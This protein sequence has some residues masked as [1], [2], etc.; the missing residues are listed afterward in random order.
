MQ[1]AP[2][3]LEDVIATGLLDERIPRVRKPAAQARA[4]SELKRVL[5]G[6]PRAVLQKLVEVALE[7][8]QAQSAGISLLE[9]SGG[10][11]F[12]RWHAVAGEWSGLLWSTLPREFSPC[13]TVLDR[14]ETLLM[15]D[16][17]RYFTQLL[18]LPPRMTEV[19]LL[20]FAV[21]GRTVGTIW[22]VAH[23][24][25]R[26]FDRKDR[27]VVAELTRFAVGAYERLQSFR[28]E[29]VQEL[30]RMHHLVSEPKSKSKSK[31]KPKPKPKP[32]AKPK[33]KPETAA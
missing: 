17:Q 21:R 28:A 16:P 12:F 11:R 4:I 33:P 5:A 31:L 9:E 30:S 29:D 23:D 1:A 7:L 15:L 32:R 20:P 22:V 18:Q 2:I 6:S 25:A 24:E 3:L 10:R 14:E 27:R 19:L 13:G 8:C 26:R